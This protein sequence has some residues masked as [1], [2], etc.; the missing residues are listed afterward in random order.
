MT[1]LYYFGC[2]SDKGHYLH[3]Q[4]GQIA[5]HTIGISLP[6][7]YALDGAFCPLSTEPEGAWQFSQVGPW[8]IASC[9]DFKI[10]SRPGSHSTFIGRYSPEIQSH[11]DLLRLS[12]IHISEPTRLLSIS[13]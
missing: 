5:P 1:Q 12:L 13:Y 9:W 6:L 3:D 7:S 11:G 2:W 4:H 10:D 8:Y